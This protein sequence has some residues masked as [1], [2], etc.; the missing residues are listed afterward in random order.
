MWINYPTETYYYT[1]SDVW[2][3][4]KGKR[5]A[6]KV[7]LRTKEKCS[8]VFNTVWVAYAYIEPMD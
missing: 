3:E 1:M 5:S 6:N 2:K 4:M 8:P 7:C